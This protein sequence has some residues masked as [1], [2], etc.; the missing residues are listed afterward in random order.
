MRFRGAIVALAVLTAAAPA[1]AQDK[2]VPYWASIASG[3]AMMRTG[4]ARTYPGTWLYQRRDLPVRVLKRYETWR[5]IEDPDGEKG[6]MLSTLLSERRTVL[7]KAGD[8]KPI[9]A[10]ASTGSRVRYRVEAGVI[11]AIDHCKDGWCHIK[12]GKREGFAEVKN[13]W[14]VAADE[15][16]D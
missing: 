5:L 16:V 1:S 7:V 10:A 12:I 3:Q 2:A 8:P 4:P 9:Y 11:G 14:G 13:L 6:W 15:V